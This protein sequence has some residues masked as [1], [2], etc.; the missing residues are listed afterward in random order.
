MNAGG[1]P[2]PAARRRRRNLSFD[3]VSFMAV[4]LGLPLV[5]FLVFVIYPF[6]EAIFFSLT[7][8]NGIA[9]TYQVIGLGNFTNLLHDDTF[10][11]ALRN[12]I[13]MGIVVP[14]ITIAAAIAIATVVTI[15]G[16]S[17]GTL[18]GIGGAGFYRVVSFFPYTVPAI[19]VGLLWGFNIYD[20]SGG[21]LN[22]VLTGLGLH[23]FNNF[24]WTGDTTTALPAMMVVIIWSFIGFYT[25]LFVAAIKGIPAEIYEA[26]RM[27]GA[28]RLR[29]AVSITVPMIRDNVQT[30]YIYLGIAALDGFVYAQALNSNG[31][32]D[33]S[34]L[35]MSQD[36][37]MTMRQGQY[38]YATAMGVALAIVTLAFAAIVF[39]VNRLTGGE[40]EGRR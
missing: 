8:W 39:A 3:R 17:K 2:R 34:T 10:L 26:A 22:G 5:T 20:P 38:G 25:V 40:R 36:L 11:H 31:G 19:A 27:D 14:L 15:G 28:G 12:N 30:A 23:G 21:L 24:A 1:R 13:E 35:T 4:F 6:G 37:L 16:P 18:R 33:N 32:T 29:M 7:N 9:P